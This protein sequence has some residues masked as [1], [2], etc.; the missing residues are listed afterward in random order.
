MKNLGAFKAAVAVL[1]IPLASSVATG[2]GE[3]TDRPSTVVG[4]SDEI[5]KS[6]VLS[7]RASI[8]VSAISGSV[9][10]KA[11]DGEA[12]NV[13]ITRRAPSRADLDC[14]EPVV[15]Q[16][17]NSLT[18]G[19]RTEPGGGC[20][21]IRVVYRVVLAVPR[22]AD[23]AVRGVSGPVGIEGLQ[24]ALRISGNSGTITVNLRRLGATGLDLSGNSGAID[25][26]VSDETNA[27]VWVSGLSGSFKSMLP[28]V[29]V[30]K[31]GIADYNA[32]IG[33]GGSAIR[34]VGHSGTVSIGSYD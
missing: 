3:A 4:H 10:V 19:S 6:F 14:N 21:N 7:P 33:R 13:N 18:V 9:E 25:L 8:D 16:V 26:R 31:T 27:D 5:N 30:T 20:Q 22:D 15:E 29:R 1:S 32:R 28:S 34:V 23:L 17:G 24:G 2:R 12:V 11:S